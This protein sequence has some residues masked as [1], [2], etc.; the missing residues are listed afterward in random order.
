M[1]GR[2]R[3]PM[4]V[5]SSGVVK[6]ALPTEALSVLERHKVQVLLEDGFSQRDVAAPSIDPPLQV[7]EITSPS[8]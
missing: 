5:D 8:T 3:V 7:I 6:C 1:F 2:R 4:M